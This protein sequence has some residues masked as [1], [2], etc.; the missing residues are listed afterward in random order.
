MLEVLPIESK[1]EQERLCALCGAEYLPDDLAYSARADGALA[2]VC[3][4]RTGPGGGILHTLDVIPGFE[5]FEPGFVMCRAAMSFIEMCG[6][7]YA[8]ASAALA[9]RSRAL[10][11][12]AGFKQTKDGLPAA[13]LPGLFE[14]PCSSGK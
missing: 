10:L 5:D 8:V 4:F 11:S 6:G 7:E 2:G 13:Y 12:A 1:A 14:H 9:Q 3:Q